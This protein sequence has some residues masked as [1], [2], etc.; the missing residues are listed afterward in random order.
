MVPADVTRAGDVERV[1]ETTI[2][3]YGKL[4]ILHNNVGGDAPGSLCPL[5]DKATVAAGDLTNVSCGSR[6]RI[7]VDD[8]AGPVYSQ[9]QTVWEPRTQ[10]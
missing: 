3:R 6:A 9:L 10:S 2:Q 1:V 8:T 7:M 4:D 5:K